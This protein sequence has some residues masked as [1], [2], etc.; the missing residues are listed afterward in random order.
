MMRM[1]SLFYMQGVPV[2]PYRASTHGFTMGDREETLV[3]LLRNAM[4]LIT[5]P[6]EN[7]AHSKYLRRINEL[8]PR[9]MFTENPDG[10]LEH[11]T[12]FDICCKVDLWLLPTACGLELAYI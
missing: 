1:C 3:K 4:S 12:F 7:A 2:E 8:D 9:N 11:N 10:T 5:D 6:L